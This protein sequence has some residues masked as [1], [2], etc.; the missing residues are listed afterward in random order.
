MPKQVPQTTLTLFGQE[1]LDTLDRQILD[2][3]CKHGRDAQSFNKLVFEVGAFASR[4]TF[5]LREKRLEKLNYIESVRDVENSQIKR[6]RGKPMT[7]LLTRIASRMKSQCAE[8]EQAIHR[9]AEIIRAR[10]TLSKD[11]LNKEV[12]FIDDT[13]EK[14]KGVF[15]LIGVYAVNLGASA[16]SDFLLPMVIG[17]FSRLNSELG[18]FL[19]SHPQ[20]R[21][22]ILHEKLGAMPP[23]QLKAD[24]KYA[25]GTETDTAL[26]KFSRRLKDIAKTRKSGLQV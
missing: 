12:E 20:L 25:F 17:D 26:P 5:A 23:D 13:N 2:T 9:R 22:A 24:F 4:S 19:T 16:A 6:I 14:V 21:R 11:E 18:A 1:P 8:L 7:L 10:K 15:S 3:I